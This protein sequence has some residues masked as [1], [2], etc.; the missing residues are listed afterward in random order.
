MQT[1]E[2]VCKN[3]GDVIK[4][5]YCSNCGEKIYSEK[6][7]NVWHLLEEAFHFITHFEGTFFNTLKAILTRPGKLSLD[8]C[9]GIRKK[10]FKPLSFF[11]LLVVIYLLFPVFEALNQSLYYHVHNSIYGKYAMQK[12]ISVMQTKHLSDAQM[13][14]LFHHK[15][16]KV[17]KFLLF[18]IIP[19]MALFSW[20]LGFKKRKLFFD[21]FIFSIEE[22]SFFLLW[23][24]LF[25][26]LLVSMLRLFEPASFFSEYA[27]L[28]AIVVV[29]IVHLFFAARK[30]FQ[31]KLGYNIFFSFAYTFFLLLVIQ[32]LYKFLLFVITINQI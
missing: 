16:E 25:L 23:G 1:S 20:L 6:D 17:S 8:Y 28:A 24:F 21:H 22:G 5:K 19:F 29:F 3:C 2:T 9:N 32:I 27:T 14:E 26:P 30:F 4:G 7:K 13:T 12:T 10:Y 15:G 31:F 11:L 18:I